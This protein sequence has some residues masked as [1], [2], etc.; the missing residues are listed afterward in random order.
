VY[1]DLSPIVYGWLVV[2]G[3]AAFWAFVSLIAEDIRKKRRRRRGMLWKVDEYGNHVLVPARK[4][5]PKLR[6]S[7]RRVL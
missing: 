7:N 5:H 1:N 3:A 2:F 6:R 4:P